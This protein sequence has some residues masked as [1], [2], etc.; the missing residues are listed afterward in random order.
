MARKK[1]TKTNAWLRDPARFRESVA[2][3]QAASRPPSCVADEFAPDAPARRI[4][5]DPP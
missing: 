3:Q 2:K 5:F 4:R 1:R